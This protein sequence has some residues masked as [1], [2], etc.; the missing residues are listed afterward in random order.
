MRERGYA[1]SLLPIFIAP[2]P[3]SVLAIVRLPAR[4]SPTI[5]SSSSTLFYASPTMVASKGEW[6]KSKVSATTLEEWVTAGALPDGSTGAWWAA[7]GDEQPRTHQGEFVMFSSFLDRGLAFRP[8]G[9]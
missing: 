2:P 3:L 6:A 9:G 1:P 5:G 7:T 8:P 4:R